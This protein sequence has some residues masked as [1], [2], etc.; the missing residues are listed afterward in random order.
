MNV[1]PVFQYYSHLGPLLEEASSILFEVLLGGAESADDESASGLSMAFY[2]FDPRE[3]LKAVTLLQTV[4]PGLNPISAC[5][6]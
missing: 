4:P 2:L 6:R 5:A 1:G 3:N